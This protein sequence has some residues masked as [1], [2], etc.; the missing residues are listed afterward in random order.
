[1]AFRHF[2]LHPD[3]PEDGL[4][5]EELFAGR[6]ID[7]PRAQRRMASLMA[8]EGLR[9]GQRTMT[10]NSRM[11]QELAAWAVTQLGGDRIHDALFRAYF[12]DGVNIAQVDNLVEIAEAAGL[13]GADARDVLQSRRFKNAV[14]RD[15]WHSRQLGISGVPTFVAGNRGVVGW[16]P[17]EDLEQLVVQSGAANR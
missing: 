2:P 15:W 4:T 3:T 8:E 12:V 17:Y 7:I 1:M 5:L 9:Y 6:N 13:S 11:A 10:F 14:D 16:Q